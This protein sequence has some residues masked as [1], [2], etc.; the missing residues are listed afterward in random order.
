MPDVSIPKWVPVS[1]R[2]LYAKIA[3]QHGEEEAA[4]QIRSRKRQLANELGDATES[5][6]ELGASQ[7]ER[8]D[9]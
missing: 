6:I 2:N 7:T 4:S 9:D 5:G 8:A 1:L 3:A